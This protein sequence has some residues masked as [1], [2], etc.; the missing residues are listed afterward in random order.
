MTIDEINDILECLPFNQDNPP[1]FYSVY[2]AGNGVIIVFGKCFGVLLHGQSWYLIV[3][4]DG[5]WFYADTPDG[6]TGWL[7]DMTKIF[8]TADKWLKAHGEPYYYV[9]TNRICGYR[10]P[11]K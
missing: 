9:N 5:Q 3:E 4:D 6:S 2:D 8:A 1:K 10:V 7:K 11:S